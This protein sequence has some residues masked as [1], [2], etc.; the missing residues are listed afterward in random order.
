MEGSTVV[1]LEGEGGD[2]LLITKD[3]T[4]A[5]VGFRMDGRNV[6]GVKITKIS[7]HPGPLVGGRATT[8][9]PLGGKKLFVGCDE[10]DARILKWKRKGEK[11]KQIVLG[12][13]EG[14]EPDRS[15]LGLVEMGSM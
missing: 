8:A 4:A 9:V 5:I 13:H 2:L 10:G 15:A 12:L 1:E 11:K 14:L 7:N 6:S 3:G